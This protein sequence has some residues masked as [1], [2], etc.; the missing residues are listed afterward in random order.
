MIHVDD[1]KYALRLLAKKP[2]FTVLTT[3][4][5][6]A[7]IGLSIYM[8]SFFNTIVFKSLPFTDGKSLVQISSSLDGLKNAG[9]VNMYDYSEIRST[10]KGLGEFGAYRIGDKNVA[11][12]DGARRYTAT[13]AEPN[14]FSLTRVKPLMGREFTD[15]ENRDGA[16]RVVV[17]G[18]DVWQNQFGGDS[19]IIEKSIRI[20]GETHRIIG[21]MPEGYVFP[22]NSELWLP[23]REVPGQQ[24]R[25]SAS[26]V[27]GLAHIQ[28]GFAQEEI[29]KQIDLI[30]QRVKERYPKTTNGLGAYISSIPLADEGGALPFIISVHVI[31]ILVL[32][33]A[34]INVGNLLLSRA[35]ERSRETAI[36]V[37]LGA[38]KGRL[39]SQMLWESILICLIGGV[40]GLL[41]LAWGLEVTTIITKS[42]F[43]DQPPFWWDFGLNA[44]NIKLFLIFVVGA[45]I[46][47]GLLPAWKN[48]GADFNAVLRDGTRGALGRKAGRLNRFLIKSEIFVSMTVLIAAC[49]MMVGNYKASRAD[50]GAKTENILIAEILLPESSYETLES[51]EQFAKSL[52]SQLENTAGIGEVMIASA[53]PGAFAATSE[54]VLDGNEYSEEKG[55]PRANYI[56]VAYGSLEK[57]GVEL[58]Q[59][60]YFD[61]SDEGLD[62]QTAIVTDSFVQ[63]YFPGGESVL[64]KRIRNAEAGSDEPQWLTIVGVIKHTI[65]GP[66]YDEKGKMPSVFRP[67][68]Q[69]PQRQISVAVQMKSERVEVENALRRALSAIDPDLP[70]FRI[71][72]YAESLTRYTAP[73]LF[74]TTV[75]LLL[76][77][78]AV[79]LAVSGIYGVMSNIVNQRTQEIGVKRALGAP[80]SEVTKDFLMTGLKQFLWGGIP[81]LLAGAG[82]GFAMSQALSVDNGDLILISTLLTLII[83][84]AVMLATYLPT[85][86]VLLL[87]PSQALRYE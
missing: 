39:I 74:M 64:G 44:F 28:E 63:K 27:Y 66:S 26:S 37:A 24:S 13:E 46:L 29:N 23:L 38:P 20:N 72:P 16:E 1:I 4:V 83:G 53:L 77:V 8:F 6:A 45:V 80:D 68:S 61:A 82:L 69:N 65:H 33:L 70:A 87:E 73:V 36:R 12:R 35:V 86:R 19:N 71:Q 41:I 58:R 5:M 59:G 50:Y 57:L 79:I 52:E 21:V 48:A 81:G 62:K 31:S 30:I 34:S 11:G 7:G 25:E 84:G 15:N 75:I 49:V 67:F 17:I 85:K 40:I 78:T 22:G 9:M 43:P 3:L 32:I 2:G 55:Y 42:F 51:Q 18:Y 47:T 10:V 14:I 76:G 56:S 60:R 54:F